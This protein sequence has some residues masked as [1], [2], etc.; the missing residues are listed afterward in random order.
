M[1]NKENDI[2]PRIELLTA[3]IDEFDTKF[4][5]YKADSMKQLLQNTLEFIKD[6]QQECEKYEQALN[7]I[8]EMAKYNNFLVRDPFCGTGYRDLSGQILSIINKV[9]R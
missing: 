3:N 1:I 5:T 7:E 6:K 9:K 4:V 8:E 2:K